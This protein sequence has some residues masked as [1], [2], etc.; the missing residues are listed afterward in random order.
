MR[1]RLKLLADEPRPGRPVKLLFGRY[2]MCDFISECAPARLS[3]YEVGTALAAVNP[4]AALL[5][6]NSYG[7][8]RK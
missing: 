7:R 4:G 1:W 3:R 2:H 8:H 5:V 6:P